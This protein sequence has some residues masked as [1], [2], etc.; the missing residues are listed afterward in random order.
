MHIIMPINAN[1]KARFLLGLVGSVKVSRLQ[2][3]VATLSN[4]VIAGR[5][6]AGILSEK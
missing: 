5:W 1:W 2:R 4:R 6:A 3:L